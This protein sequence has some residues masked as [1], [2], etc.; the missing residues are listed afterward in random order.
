M[1]QELEVTKLTLVDSAGKPRAMLYCDPGDFAVHLHF[2][3]K[4]GFPRL[5][6]NVNDGREAGLLIK[7]PGGPGGIASI[8]LWIDPPNAAI[9]HGQTVLQL[10][11]SDGSSFFTQQG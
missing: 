8:S 6:L 1:A 10:K 11:A 3:D 2:F 5:E 9:P 7:G 4:D